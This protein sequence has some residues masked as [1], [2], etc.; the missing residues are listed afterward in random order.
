VT[1]TAV[2][3]V[4]FYGKLPSHGDFVRRRVSDH[5]VECWD[6]WLQEGISASRALLGDRWLSVYLTS[7]AWRFVAAAGVL[8]REPM[9]G[10]MIPSVDRVGRYF[11]LTIA[12]PLPPNVGVV[13][14]ATAADEFLDRAEQLAV[15]T[16]IAD[17]I[18]FDGFDAGVGS[19]ALALE[20]LAAAPRL[21]LDDAAAGVTRQ[22]FGCRWRIGLGESRQLAPMFDQLFAGH[23]AALYD[24]LVIW[25]T[26]GSENVEP[27]CLI[28][29]G[30][31]EAEGFTALMDGA[32]QQRGW[33]VAAGRLEGPAA[34]EELFDTAIMVDPTPPR[35]K[36]VGVSNVGK[37]R[38]INQD[39][40]LERTD[41][42]LWVVA[43]G[44]GGH[45][46]G[47]VASR[48]V[49]DGLA[50]LVPTAS[51][52]E[53]IEAASARIRAVNGQL[54]REAEREDRRSGSTVVAMMA[55][56]SRYAVVWAGDSRLYHYRAGRLEQVTR[57]HSAGDVDESGRVSTAITRAVGA[58]PALELDLIRGR[59]MPGDRFLLCSDGLTRTVP[60]DEIQRWLDLPDAQASVNALLK[61]TLDAG[62]PDNVTVVIVEAFT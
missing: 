47:E 21:V 14:G 2:T 22:G 6:R 5:F 49:C 35:F 3:E 44:L 31:P 56:G 41:V 42:G 12:A 54:V 1:G 4:G 51:F 26:E 38:S 61:A 18:D 15:E 11:P 36:S 46:N 27:S 23:L 33:T 28:G 19:L 37:I 48:M 16:V 17:R 24:P 62:A 43:D 30:L 32:W 40:Y 53:T 45:S 10:V 59:V 9:I 50:D 58:E 29:K 7:P 55:R 57:D 20:S 13:T 8:D 39:S 34:P 60:D 52:E 25:W